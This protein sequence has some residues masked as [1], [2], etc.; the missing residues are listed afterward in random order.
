M[1]IAVADMPHDRR[2][3]AGGRDVGLAAQ[4]FTPIIV[5]GDNEGIMTVFPGDFDGDGDVDF[6]TT[7]PTQFA[8]KY[9]RNELIMA[10]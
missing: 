2:H 7:D 8:V 1:E 4:Q 6:F 10:N 9:F 3:Q 5:S